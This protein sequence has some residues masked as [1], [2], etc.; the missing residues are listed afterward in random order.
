[1]QKTPNQ[2]KLLWFGSTWSKHK[3]LY[4][5]SSSTK[6]ANSC[7]SCG[8]FLV[9]VNKSRIL[10]A[11]VASVELRMS[12]WLESFS[13]TF[14]RNSGLSKIPKPKLVSVLAYKTQE[15]LNG[16][17]M[18]S[19]AAARVTFVSQSWDKGAC[20]RRCCPG[21]GRSMTALQAQPAAPAL[22][23]QSC[24]GWSW[25]KNLTLE[26]MLPPEGLSLRGYFLQGREHINIL[27]F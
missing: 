5:F 26:W 7:R 15:R 6:A 21:D 8:S 2:T 11:A 24:G 16:C 22:P 18:V 9:E 25:E 4:R 23:W 17:G 12:L 27:R 13:L 20:C 14:L 1:M 3:L 19:P 10:T